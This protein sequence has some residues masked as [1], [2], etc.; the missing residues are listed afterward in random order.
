MS[1]GKHNYQ[2]G[3]CFLEIFKLKI[4]KTKRLSKNFLTLS[5]RPKCG[6][7]FA[8]CWEYEPHEND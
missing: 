4:I 5:I 8:V 2:L 1:D 6:E 3:S 7:N